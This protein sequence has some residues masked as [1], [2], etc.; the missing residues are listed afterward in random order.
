VALNIKN[1]STSRS[2]L[3]KSV[4]AYFKL[5]QSEKFLVGSRKLFQL[6]IY[7]KDTLHMAKALMCIGDYYEDTVQLDSAF[8]YYSKSE[9]LFKYIGGSVEIGKLTLYK[10]GILYEAGIF[11]ESEIQTATALRYLIQSDND[12]LIYETYNLMGLNLTELG[13]YEK[14]LDYYN[15]AF[16]KLD[17]MEKINYSPTKLIK[18]RASI[19]NNCGN[20]YLK[21]GV[22]SKAIFHYKKCLFSPIIKND[23]PILYAMVIDNLAFAM[24]KQNSLQNVEALFLESITIR[25]SLKISSGMVTGQIHLGVFYLNSGDTTKALLYFKDGLKIAKEIKST[26]DIKNALELLSLND[27]QNRVHYGTLYINI[28]DSLQNIERNTRNKFARI[29]YETNQI[30]EKNESLLKKYMSTV[31]MFSGALLLFSVMFIILRLKSRNTELHYIKNQQ[32]SNEKIYQ[33][34]WEQKHENQTARHEERHRIALELHD[35]IVN[36][37][38]TT[39]FN[40]MLLKLDENDQKEK[41]VQELVTVEEEIRKVSHDL[42][43]NL[44]FE[45]TSFQIALESLVVNQTNVMN[46]Q[47]DCSIDTYIDWSLVPSAYKVHIYRI[48]QEA[49]HN[50]NKY[51][52]ATKCFVFLLKK[53]TK[54]SLQISDN[55][56]GFDIEKKKQGIGLKNM[57]QRAKSIK[58]SF[59]IV[60]DSSGTTIEILF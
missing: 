44:A 16:E 57:Q 56:V 3:L 54:I 49:L 22:F 48:C 5:N 21:K 20:V 50:V 10:A 1:D 31:L 23:Y 40:L 47:F 38:F 46:T 15:L 24:M 6:S 43:Q 42:Q 18:S 4:R 37:V 19:H 59:S 33:L 58:G 35:G 17:A 51:A 55:G 9:K 7:E 60:S 28:T 2:T 14:A 30:E 36:R 41:L 11:T 53:G 34:I 26:Y 39:R 13:N 45:D 27:K 8:T 29:A 52:Q 32:D 25:D 12:R